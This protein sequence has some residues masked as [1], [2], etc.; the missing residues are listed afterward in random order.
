[1]LSAECGKDEVMRKETE[2][3]KNKELTH[4]IPDVCK[5]KRKR[6]QTRKGNDSADQKGRKPTRPLLR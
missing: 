3:V 1:M 4:G 6:N 5:K 2:D